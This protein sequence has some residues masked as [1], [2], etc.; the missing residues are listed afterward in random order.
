[1][2]SVE[3]LVCKKGRFYSL[4]TNSQKPVLLED[5]DDSYEQQVSVMTRK[6]GVS[7][8]VDYC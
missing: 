1:M 6:A 3:I 4:D 2:V 5:G 7:L 8:H